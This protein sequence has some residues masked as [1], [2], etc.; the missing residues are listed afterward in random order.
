MSQSE[1]SEYILETQKLKGLNPT[2]LDTIISTT[3]KSGAR[4]DWQDTSEK[5]ICF[6]ESS[7]VH[8]A[9]KASAPASLS[10]KNRRQ[11]RAIQKAISQEIQGGSRKGRSRILRGLEEALKKLESDRRSVNKVASLKTQPKSCPKT[12]LAKLPLS[13]KSTN[14]RKPLQTLN[15]LSS[16]QVPEKIPGLADL[17]PSSS[18][19]IV[20]METKKT[21]NGRKHDEKREK[22]LVSEDHDMDQEDPTA[23]HEPAF[24]PLTEKC[25]HYTRRA[26][27]DWDIQKSGSNHPSDSILTYI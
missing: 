22:L 23:E 4:Q 17:A 19:T 12:H 7:K 11:I 10:A 24:F 2:P 13:R 26:D 25:H 20:T 15:Q 14:Q 16:K 18:A 3:E 5:Q 8:R 21:P 1:T 9:P 27:V 6:G